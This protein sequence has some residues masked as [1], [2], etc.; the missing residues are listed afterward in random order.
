LPEL[1]VC[2]LAEPIRRKEKLGPTKNAFST[3]I[4]CKS[5]KFCLVKGQTDRL[6]LPDN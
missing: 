3:V 5:E 4:Y 2:Q 6:A 1:Y